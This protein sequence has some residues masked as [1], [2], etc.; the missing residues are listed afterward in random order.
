MV[1]F[2]IGTIEDTFHAAGTLPN[3]MD[4]LNRWANEEAMDSAVPF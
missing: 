2:G 1:I 4:V 3:L